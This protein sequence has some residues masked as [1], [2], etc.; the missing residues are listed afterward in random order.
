MFNPDKLLRACPSCVAED[1]NKRSFSYWRRSHQVPGRV[2]CAVH[3]SALWTTAEPEL[4]PSGPE[5][6]SESSRPFEEVAFRRLANNAFVSR[7]LAILDTI[8]LESLHIDWD[9]CNRALRKAMIDGVDD[10]SS[11][12][13]MHA[14]STLIETAFTMDWLTYA[15]PGASLTSGGTHTFVA[16]CLYEKT[17]YAPY[18]SMAVV[19]SFLFPTAEA[20]LRE[21]GA[22]SLHAA[23]CKT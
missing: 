4:A 7:A 11:A 10:R 12:L 9:A 5:D 13:S 20:A 14:I 19:A 3:G 22:R 23:A 1:V 2:A 8:M 18:V 6:V 15:K 16:H 17:E 21:M